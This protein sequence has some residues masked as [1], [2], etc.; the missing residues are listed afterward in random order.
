MTYTYMPLSFSEFAR[1]PEGR[2]EIDINPI[3]AQEHACRS[4]RDDALIPNDDVDENFL[5][6]PALACLC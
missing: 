2:S 1:I 3:S 5:E 4:C 6:I